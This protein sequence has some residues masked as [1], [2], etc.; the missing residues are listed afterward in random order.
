VNA[1]QKRKELE[2]RAARL[3]AAGARSCLSP[4]NFNLQMFEI[5]LNRYENYI[6]PLENCENDSPVRGGKI[7]NFTR[8]QA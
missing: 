1:K 7:L 4:E 8:G 6:L 3:Q 2:N 5:G